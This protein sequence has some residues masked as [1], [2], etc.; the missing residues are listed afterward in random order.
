MIPIPQLFHTRMAHLQQVYTVHWG[1][2]G[3]NE[4]GTIHEIKNELH[5]KNIDEKAKD[6]YECEYLLEIAVAVNMLSMAC[7]NCSAKSLE[8]LSRYFQ[9]W[10]SLNSLFSDIILNNLISV[11]RCFL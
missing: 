6:V 5:R 3:K 8:K 11:R 7:I 10:E 9:N 1:A 4:L 2:G